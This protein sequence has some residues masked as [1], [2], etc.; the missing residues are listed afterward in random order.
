MVEP[1]YMYRW[2][3]VRNLRSMGGGVGD[4]GRKESE[5]PWE[6]DRSGRYKWRGSRMLS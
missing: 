6:E 2:G 1:G 4:T 3:I 5:G